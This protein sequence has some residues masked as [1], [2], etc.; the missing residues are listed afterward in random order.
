SLSLIWFFVDEPA[1]VREDTRKFRETFVP[2]WLGFVLV[3]VTFGCLQVVLDRFEQDDGFASTSIVVFATATVFSAISLVWWEL[4]HPQPVFDVRLFKIKS[5]AAANVLMF[6]IGFTL[7]STTQLIPQLAQN[8]LHYDSLKAGQSLALGGVAAVIVMPFAGMAAN[9]LP[10]KWLI[11]AAFVVTGFALLHTSGLNANVSF[12]GLSMTRVYQSV[13]LPFLFVSLTTAAYVGIP[14]EKNNEASAVINL[15]RNLGGSVGVAMATT[16]L[17]WRTQFHHA[18]LA[19]NV[20]SIGERGAALAH[21]GLAA[22]QQLVQSQA[23]MLSYLDIFWLWGVAAICVAPVA[24]L[25]KN[26]PKGVASHGGH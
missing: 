23:Q 16:E 4:R 13:A 25:L 12:W 8:L 21:N 26:Q 22:A 9:K 24:L 10:P 1:A 15:F 7:F 6:L 20:S 5:F 2:D 17:A 18:R 14:P 11:M 19:E 3:A